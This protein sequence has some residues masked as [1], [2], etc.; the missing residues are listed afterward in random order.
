M[1]VEGYKYSGRKIADFIHPN[2]NE[3]LV[4]LDIIV[5]VF[6]QLST[7]IVIGLII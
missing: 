1:S 4:S 3:K 5:A 7:A 2:Y 6:L